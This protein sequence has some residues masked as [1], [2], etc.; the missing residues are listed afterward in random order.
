MYVVLLQITKPRNKE[1]ILCHQKI[2]VGILVHENIF[3]MKIKTQKSM[4]LHINNTFLS[5]LACQYQE[6][7]FHIV[8]GKWTLKY[9]ETTV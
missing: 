8:L 9:R 3:Y 7:K 5:T 1:S 2:F 6:L 4:V